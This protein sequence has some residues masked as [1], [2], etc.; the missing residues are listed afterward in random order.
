MDMDQ[1]ERLTNSEFDRVI[2][3]APDFLRWADRI[4]LKLG[5]G[6]LSLPLWSC[7]KMSVLKAVRPIEVTEFYIENST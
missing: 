2:S 4:S 6:T 5:N 7:S 3:H 1:D